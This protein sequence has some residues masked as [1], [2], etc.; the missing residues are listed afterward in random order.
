MN[1][2]PGPS[3]G[4]KQNMTLPKSLAQPLRSTVVEVSC[5]F[6]SRPFLQSIVHLS[7]FHPFRFVRGVSPFIR[8]PTPSRPSQPPPHERTTRGVKPGDRY[9]SVI[10][11]NHKRK[12][13]VVQGMSEF[14][15]PE[16]FNFLVRGAKSAVVEFLLK[17]KETIGNDK[18]L[19]SFKVVAG[20]GCMLRVCRLVAVKGSARRTPKDLRTRHSSTAWKS[21]RRRQG[22]GGGTAV[23]PIERGLR[24]N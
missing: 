24:T 4:P 9:V 17:E 11:G 18:C 10:C 8:H 12:T 21:C 15:C 14:A 2:W 22:G 23:N 20:E 19:G 16:V 5:A 1:P 7:R 3:S 13:A 6:A